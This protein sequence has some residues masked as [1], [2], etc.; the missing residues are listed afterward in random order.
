MQSHPGYS[1]EIVCVNDGSPDNLLEVLVEIAKKDSLCKVLDCTK[2]NGQHT[3][4]IAGLAYAGGE[5]I[6]V[7]DDDGQSPVQ[8]LFHMMDKMDEGYDVV[9]ASYDEK[10][11]GGVRSFGSWL[12]EKMLCIILHKPKNIHVSNFCLMTRCIAKAVSQCS[13]PFPY[14]L[15]YILSCTGNVANVSMPGAPRLAGV[16]GYS[17][18]KLFRLWFTGLI[19]FSV[20]PL[21]IG[22]IF[23]FS[24]AFLGFLGGLTVC[25]RKLLNPAMAAGWP[26]L[27]CILIFGFGAVLCMLGLIGEYI[28]RIHLCVNRIPQYVIRRKIN[29][30]EN[31]GKNE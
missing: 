2:N 6:I 18:G 20:V 25:F 13:V 12:N 26:S 5:R 4:V 3:A 8:N 11:N 7:I 28:G 22:T 9:W 15:G 29:F 16:S 24:C 21:R 30:S 17:L 27:F 10:C 19:S 31:E 14:I 23:G 1:Y